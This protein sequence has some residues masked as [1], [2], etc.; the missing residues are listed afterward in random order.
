MM[1]RKWIKLTFFEL[2]LN[3][4]IPSLDNKV[5]E[6]FWVKSKYFLLKFKLLL[7]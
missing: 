4:M 2:S 1:I 3:Q 6:D 7:S 5:V